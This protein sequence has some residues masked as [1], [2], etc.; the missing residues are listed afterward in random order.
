MEPGIIK[1]ISRDDKQVNLIFY[2]IS[3]GKVVDYKI[4][5]ANKEGLKEHSKITREGLNFYLF[6]G[7]I[8]KNSPSKIVQ[9]SGSIVERSELKFEDVMEVENMISF[10]IE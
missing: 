9:V 7:A 5:H 2:D 3:S 1:F 10:T 8:K 4:D 6:Y